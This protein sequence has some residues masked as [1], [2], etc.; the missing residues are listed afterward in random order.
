[1]IRILSI[2]I[3]C[4]LFTLNLSSQSAKDVN[5]V[6]M[7]AEKT[8][9]IKIFKTTKGKYAG[10]IIWLRDGDKK[11]VNNPDKDKR[12][13]QLMGLPIVRGFKWN[14][15]DKKWQGGL[16]Y[17]PKKGKTYSCYMYFDSEDKSTLS[18]RG[19]IMGMKWLGRTTEWKRVK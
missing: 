14:E 7:N 18:L 8:A 5:G 15:Y 9:K 10:K 13:R 4:F 1:M 19:Y 6:W 16:I 11:D 2:T 12:D 17:D 3:L